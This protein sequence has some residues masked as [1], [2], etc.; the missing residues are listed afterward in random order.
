[1]VRAVLLL[2]LLL[3]AGP[4]AAQTCTEHIVDRFD[5]APRATGIAPATCRA[6]GGG[7]TLRAAIETAG[8]HA[9]CDRVVLRAG[10][11]GLTI[12]D[13]PAPANASAMERAQWSLRGASGAL[14][15]ASLEGDD[16][17][18]V[19][20]GS[21]STIIT[22]Q[23]NSSRVFQLATRSASVSAAR[24][25]LVVIRGL[26]LRGGHS[27]ED[28]GAV[29]LSACYDDPL[30]SMAV[31]DAAGVRVRCRAPQDVEL[32]DVA[33][34]DSRAER[35]GG[36]LCY[37][38]YYGAQWSTYQN[39]FGGNVLL[40][41]VA[42]RRNQAGQDG[43]ALTYYNPSPG[44]LVVGRGGLL[45]EDNVAGANGG[46]I[47]LSSAIGI[48]GYQDANYAA[49]GC[50]GG[51][52]T[53]PWRCS[54]D[55]FR[56]GTDVLRFRHNRARNG[57]GMYFAS[58]SLHL[59]RAVFEDNEA[60]EH[61]GGLAV[62]SNVY[63]YDS[64]FQGNRAGG[65]GGGAWVPN[66]YAAA[67]AL[68]DVVFVR[69]RAQ[70]G[71][72]LWVAHNPGQGT[73]AA[74]YLVR[75][76]F[77]ENE[78]GEAGGGLYIGPSAVGFHVDLATF[79]D[80]RVLS[81]GGQGDSMYN[82]NA[83]VAPV[84]YGSVFEQN[85][86]DVAGRADS[87]FGP[88]ESGGYNLDEANTC[89]R[90]SLDLPSRVSLL[91]ALGAPIGAADPYGRQVYYPLPGSPLID[92]APRSSGYFWYVDALGRPGVQDGDNDGVERFDLGAIEAPAVG[93]TSDP[94]CQRW[95]SSASS[96]V[97]RRGS[98]DAQC[99][100]ATGQ[101]RGCTEAGRPSASCP[102]ELPYCTSAQHCGECL[103][104]A[105]C[106]AVTNG[107]RCID[108]VTASNGVLRGIPSFCGCTSDL[109]CG[110]AGSGRV[111]SSAQRC[112]EGCRVGGDQCPSPAACAA[113]GVCRIPC[114]DVEPC[115]SGSCRQAEPRY[116][117]E[118][119]DDQGCV[120]RT[121]GAH[122]CRDYRCQL[123]C[124]RD[125]H[126]DADRHCDPQTLVCV[127]DYPIIP[128]DAGAEESDAGRWPDAEGHLDAEG[129]PD[130]EGHLDAS[131][132]HDV[133]TISDSGA[134]DA[135]AAISDAGSALP[136][137]P[138]SC[139]AARPASAAAWI[140]LVGAIW[141]A[142]RQRTAPLG[143][144]TT[145]REARR[146]GTIRRARRAQVLGLLLLWLLAGCAKGLIGGPADAGSAAADAEEGPRDSSQGPGPDRQQPDGTS[147]SDATISGVDAGAPDQGLPPLGDEPA[148]ELRRLTQAQLRNTVADLY[149]PR[150]I[151]A[152]VLDADPR[153]YGLSQIGAAEAVTS[154]L[155]AEQY[156]RFARELSRSLFLDAGRRAALVGTNCHPREA[157]DPCIRNYLERSGLRLWRR[158]LASIEVD[159][160]VGVV[161]EVGSASGHDLWFG[162]E[163]ALT[164]IL[165]SPNFLY[166]TTIGELDRED[167]NL[168]RYSGY[169][170]A[171]RLSFLLWD[172]IPDEALLESARRGELSTA[173]GVVAVA[174]RLMSDPKGRR[175]L[176]HFFSEHF[177]L[178]RLEPFVRDPRKFP[179]LPETLSGSMRQ[180]LD[181]SLAAAAFREGPYSGRSFLAIYSSSWTWVNQ[182]LA[183][184]YGLGLS[185][186]PGEWRLIEHDPRG[187]RAG[188]L[189]MAGILA[190]GSR[191]DRSSP[192]VRGRFVRERVLCTPVANPP[193]DVNAMFTDPPD[194]GQAFQTMAERL[195]EHTA[196]PLC[197]GCHRQMDPIGLTLES[198]TA[199]GSL[200]RLPD[201]SIYSEP[202]FIDDPARTLRSARE[203]GQAVET[204]P[205]TVRC[206]SSQLTRWALGRLDRTRKDAAL[207]QTLDAQLLAE[208]D[209]RT[210]ITTVVGS[211]QFRTVPH[212]H[213][214]GDL[215]CPP[216]P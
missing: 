193:P 63:L 32:T 95:G 77:G 162:L 115:P 92:G 113:E 104:A 125:E 6:T 181:R 163:A 29:Y 11:Y 20:Q 75:L 157:N 134:A 170:L 76:S 189:G 186:A 35:D 215:R 108:A 144:G 22:A 196:N 69:N 86:P 208:G 9:G 4:A 145:L 100:I 38:P 153:S 182:D 204:D 146:A 48:P 148:I 39:G 198:Y 130:A 164:A 62:Q 51:A 195:R 82:G 112:V 49:A 135:G 210:L 78:A 187:P 17:T 52:D 36:A 15:L 3:L 83:F 156:L 65:D 184:L 131:A 27:A 5:D 56:T 206:I 120:G 179:G 123:P 214:E 33:I 202:G 173:E 129:R 165:A 143:R 34:E 44:G 150:F 46:G 45:L 70:R 166:Q 43:G 102:A 114:S 169:E 80:N 197:Q 183:D 8:L 211:D 141:L 60:T 160:L 191:T 98:N 57:G 109:D 99:I 19:G 149:G 103:S 185:L 54:P 139:T 61:G 30:G 121:D 159:D 18:I 7:C 168:R 25:G 28:C 106:Q 119:E 23:G 212:R 127:Q 136:P 31:F 47:Y 172:S 94:D 190:A 188:L 55:Y 161:R 13:P 151:P 12:P 85:N 10:T 73:T 58:W 152:V 50:P 64:Y 111:C 128:A 201:G 40:S 90:G 137:E 24:A 81:S 155:S 93:C 1:M 74:S 176:A 209:L 87:C 154:A 138:Q 192:T 132:A 26:S 2:S 158:P 105:E 97:L 116:C 207:I 140:L 174:T 91:S 178:E 37:R 177:E 101:C 67:S 175:G 107:P 133:G 84:V 203:L 71:G 205:R 213:V 42:F 110:G 147:N 194:G 41:Q 117:V 66:Q 118:C 59:G 89:A 14:T 171:E 199:V 200:A 122:R 53:H 126:C 72:G 96:N 180:E 68:E 16:T 216:S 88:L 142:R 79:K 21:G 167:P 124:T